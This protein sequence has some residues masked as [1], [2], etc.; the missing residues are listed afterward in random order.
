MMPLRLEFG[1]ARRWITGGI[2]LLFAC[3]LC[4]CGYRLSGGTASSSTIGGKSIAVPI[5]VNTTHRPNLEAIL[6]AILREE[7]A[8]RTGKMT[9]TADS[10]DLV[11]HGTVTSFSSTAVSYTA[12]DRIR[13]YQASLTVD[14]TLRERQSGAVLWKGVQTSVQ[15]FP[16]V[17]F[18]M[19]NPP[20][21]ERAAPQNRTALQQNSEDAATREL[22]R[23][24]ARDIYERIHEGF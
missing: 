18:P 1:A 7:I 17:E 16:V 6:T 5:M 10:A 9:A 20:L 11:L 3:S 4:G 12:E 22:C 2:L 8:L 13:Q 23:K 14:V 24:L 21:A 19:N 15:E